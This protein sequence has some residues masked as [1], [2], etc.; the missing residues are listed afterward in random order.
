MGMIYF[1]AGVWKFWSAGVDWALSENLKF[2]MYQKW[3]EFDGWTPFFRI[4]HYPVLYKAAALGAMT[5]EMSFVFLL[6]SRRLRLLAALAGIV[7]HGMID[8]FM[9]ISFAS[10]LSCYVAFFDWHA[11]FRRMGTW[12]YGGE[13][14]VLY[15][16]NCQLC[17]RTISLLRG[18]DVFGRVTY[19]NA[20]DDEAVR[21]H[22][23]QWLPAH[24][25][26]ADMHVVV[27]QSV[28]RGWSAYRA[29]ALRLPVLWPAV[30]FLYLWPVPVIAN[31]VY[32]QVADARTCS[33]AHVL[34]PQAESTQYGP[35]V[36]S[37]AVT[38]VGV[39]LVS[40]N[41]LAGI[42]DVSASWPIAH[43]PTFA[44]IAGPE[45]SLVEMSVQ[46]VGG[47]TISLNGRPLSRNLDSTRLLGLTGQVIAAETDAQRRIR[48]K[49]LWQLW[50]Q[51][52]PS[53]Q[54]ANAVRFYKV[55][56]SAIPE[57]RPSNPLHRELL[58]ELTL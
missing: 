44:G 38:A 17:R 12:V 40:A 24:A 41:I 37:R 42:A 25:L 3:I 49:A 56:L 55:T 2:I 50:V 31:R 20:C 5:F 9:R 4:D 27:R 16:G 53:L 58:F 51:N 6:F 48:S 15:D 28:W 22:G 34:S 47:E 32:R 26:L 46:S 1:F 21:R 33:I 14:Y 8:V 54:H 23:L 19:V 43:Y 57:R 29:L 7:F 45:M 52:D 10:L 11:I 35:A 13:M 30:P 18:F 36:G 39:F